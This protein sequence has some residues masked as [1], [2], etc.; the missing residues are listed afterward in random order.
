MINSRIS[1]DDDIIA[2]IMPLEERQMLEIIETRWIKK[3]KD[4]QQIISKLIEPTI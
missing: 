2:D 4:M 1:S 3:N